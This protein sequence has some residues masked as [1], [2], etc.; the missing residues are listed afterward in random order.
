[1]SYFR[2]STNWWQ[3]NDYDDLKKTGRIIAKA[4]VQGGS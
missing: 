3:R 1:M 2:K 4:M